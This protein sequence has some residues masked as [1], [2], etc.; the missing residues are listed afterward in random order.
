MPTQLTA[1]LLTWKTVL[2][3]PGKQTFKDARDNSN[4]TLRTALVWLTAASVAAFLLLQLRTE[5]G[6]AAG[7]PDLPR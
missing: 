2:T 4:A 1:T 5:L 3:K 6:R 7:T